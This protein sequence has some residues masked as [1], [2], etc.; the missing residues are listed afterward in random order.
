MSHLWFCVPCPF[1]S[2]KLFYQF[3]NCWSLNWRIF[4]NIKSKILVENQG[5]GLAAQGFVPFK[6]LNLNLAIIKMLFGNVAAG[7][8]HPHRSHIYQYLVT[9]KK[10]IFLGMTHQ[11]SLSCHRFGEAAFCCFL[12]WFSNDQWSMALLS[13]CSLKWIVFFFWKTRAVNW[14]YSNYSRECEQ[15]YFLFFKKISLR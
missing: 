3:L 8:V 4:F 12:W 2:Y 14:F 9:T 10:V 13:Y 5:I 6:M 11:F 7:E 1:G 15:Q